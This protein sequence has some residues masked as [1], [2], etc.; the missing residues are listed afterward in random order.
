LGYFS[1]TSITSF[2]SL[3]QQNFWEIFSHIGFH[4][5]FSGGKCP[6]SPI[7][8]IELFWRK[9]VLKNDAL[10]IAPRRQTL[11]QKLFM[12]EFSVDER[13]SIQN[14]SFSQKTSS[15]PRF[16]IEEI[17]DKGSLDKTV[18]VK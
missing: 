12:T 14:L 6:K 1:V 17:F 10:Q 3:K 4:E 8:N 18:N 7:R 2:F 11:R 15:K 9:K 5:E 16:A 13:Y